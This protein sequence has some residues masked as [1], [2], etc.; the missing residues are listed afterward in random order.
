M[1]DMA[2]ASAPAGGGCCGAASGTSGGASGAAS[3]VV[4]G[5]SLVITCVR[6]QAKVSRGVPRQGVQHA[7]A[8]MRAGA[9]C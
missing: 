5:R 1:P 8:E 3:G 4:G 6:K 2:G 7:E 9:V